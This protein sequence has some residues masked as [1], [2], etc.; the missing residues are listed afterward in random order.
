MKG[1][2]EGEKGLREEGDA[3]VEGR[4]KNLGHKADRGREEG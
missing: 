2:T 3:Q 4:D 1:V